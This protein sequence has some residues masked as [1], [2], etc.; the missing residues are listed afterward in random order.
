M[1]TPDMDKHPSS[2]GTSTQSWQTFDL[3]IDGLLGNRIQLCQEDRRIFCQKDR[4]GGWKEGYSARRMEWEVGRK[5]ILAQHTQECAES[6]Q[7]K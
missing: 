1:N 6:S 2:L 3:I 4:V 5:D 7:N